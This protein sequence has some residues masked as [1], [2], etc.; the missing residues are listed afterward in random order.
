MTGLRRAAARL[1]TGSALVARGGAARAAAWCRKSYRPDLT[2][3]RAALGPAVRVVLL[4]GAAWLLYRVV[5]AR[6]A[7]MWLLAAG[8]LI[9]AWRATRKT[10]T[11]AAE[12]EP[13]EGPAAAD[14]DAVR[15]LLVEAIGDRPGVHLST[16]LAH[17]QERGQG[18]GWQVADLRARLEALGVPVRRSVKVDRRV[19]YGVHR[20]DLPAPSPAEA[21][22]RAA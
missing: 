21:A 5:R 7:L 8:W 11:E 16:L 4:G 12:D 20:D 18:E 6:P 15:Q 10:P 13:E 14:P 2:G 17:L 19:A 1:S 22:D 9:A 3:W